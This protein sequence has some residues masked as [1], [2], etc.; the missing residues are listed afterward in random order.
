VDADTPALRALAGTGLA[1]RVVQTRPA[2]SAEE[3]AELQGIAIGEL[4]RTIVVRRGA[5][6]YV[7]VLVPGGREIDW[8]KLRAQ[9]GVN[10]L[11]LPDMDEAKAATGYE[12]G[13]IT[14][15][16]AERPWPVVA[17][18]G[19]GGLERIAIGGG[20]RGVNLHFAPADLIGYLNA[21]VVDVTR[22]ARAGPGR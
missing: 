2:R 16:G 9:L 12:R 5:D 17:D 22:P 21:Q 13:A 14:P 8:P 11:S 10:R 20:A 18:A 1:Y 7:F 3:S 4:V 6:D 19:V 15:L